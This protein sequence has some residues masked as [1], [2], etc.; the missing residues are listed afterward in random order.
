MTGKVTG[1][2]YLWILTHA[3][4]P[5]PDPYTTIKPRLERKGIMTSKT[6]QVVNHIPKHSCLTT[7]SGLYRHLEVYY[8]EQ[9]MDLDLVVPRTFIIGSSSP[10]STQSD[11][12]P[13]LNLN[14]HRECRPRGESSHRF[15]S[16]TGPPARESQDHGQGGSSQRRR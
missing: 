11:P 14:A 13:N 15:E 12:D 4:N 3:P 6:K 1:S 8:K 16:L 2:P 10:R 5:N 7:K 9:G